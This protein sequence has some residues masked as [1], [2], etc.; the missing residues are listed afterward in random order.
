MRTQRNEGK[1][2]EREKCGVCEGP[3]SFTCY[4]S[5]LCLLFLLLSMTISYFSR[6]STTSF[7]LALPLSLSLYPHLFPISL[8]HTQ[9]SRDRHR[10]PHRFGFVYDCFISYLTLFFFF[11]FG[12]FHFIDVSP[13]QWKNGADRRRQRFRRRK[14]AQREEK[15]GRFFISSIFKEFYL[16]SWASIFVTTKYRLKVRRSCFNRRNSTT[17]TFCSRGS[18]ISA[19]LFSKLKISVPILWYIF[20]SFSF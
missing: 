17:W 16:K 20:N 13:F 10:Q 11:I 8:S 18:K 12:Y 6:F 3:S 14:T 5:R 7:L 9:L 4:F 2:A 1:F 15:K 19:N